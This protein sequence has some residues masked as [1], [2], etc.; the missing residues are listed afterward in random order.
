MLVSTES[1]FDK[2]GIRHSH[3]Y[4]PLLNVQTWIRLP[5]GIV[6]SVIPV[7]AGAGVMVGGCALDAAGDGKGALCQ[8]SVVGGV[9]IMSTAP[10]VLEG[11]LRPDLR[12]WEDV[13]A[14]VVV[15]RAPEPKLEPCL[16]PVAAD[17]RPL[18]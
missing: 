10:H 5:V 4:H 13:P 16:A 3:A 6:Y 14:A 17:A 11:A 12:H 9:A 1:W 8:L 18:L 2:I 7:A 15:T